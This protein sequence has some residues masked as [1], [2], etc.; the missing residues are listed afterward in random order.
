MAKR[1]STQGMKLTDDLTRRGYSPRQ[2]RPVLAGKVTKQLKRAA[3]QGLTRREFLRNTA[4]IGAMLS[5][6][7]LLS[8]CFDSDATDGAP[9]PGTERRTLFF[10]FAHEDFARTAHHLVV[11][12]NKYPL[13]K[14]SDK[15]HVLR[16]ARQTNAFL[17]GVPDNQITHHLENVELP[18]NTVQLS[19]VISSENKTT[20]TWNMSGM[21]LLMPNASIMAAHR[22]GQT[23][24]VPAGP[25]QSVKRKRY[26]SGPA[27]TAQD[28][29]DERALF[30]TTDHAGTLVGMHP[31]ALSAEPNSC[32]YIHTHHIATN[33]FTGDVSDD[34]T[35]LGAAQP[36]VTPNKPNDPTVGWATLAP[37]TDENGV[38]LKNTTGKNNKGLIHYN[39][40]WNINVAQ[41]AAQ[42][43]TGVV[44]STK[45]DDKLGA[46]VTGALNGTP[47]DFTGTIWHR[48]DGITS[49]NQSPGPGRS[50]DTLKYTLAPDTPANGYRVT[51]TAKQN[52][53]GSVPV[54]LNLEN[55]YLR[56]LG[57]WVQFLDSNGKVVPVKNLPSSLTH[58]GNGVNT[59]N[60][61]YF[62]V[63]T[64]EFVIYAI[65]IQ[66][67]KSTVT[68]NFPTGVASQAKVL[69][70]GLGFGSH[71]FQA[72]EPVGIALTSIF[73]LIIPTILLGL[74]LVEGIDAIVKLIAIPAANAAANELAAFV[75]DGSSNSWPNFNNML[76]IFWRSLV[77]TLASPGT[78]NKFLKTVIPNLVG[79]I[80]GQGAVDAVEDALPL[81]G[82]I[83]QAIAA[84]ATV[85]EIAETSIEVLLSPW[86]YENDL[87]LTHDLTLSILP[88]QHDD[89]TPKGANRYQVTALFDNGGTPQVQ[90]VALPQP[91]NKVDVT[92]KNVP[93]GGNVNISAAF[94]QIPI[95]PS[96]DHVVLGKATTG[97]VPNNIDTLAPTNI[98]EIKF[99]IGRNTKYQHKQKTALDP[100][101]HHF[102][103]ITAP[104][105]VKKAS[106]IRCAVQGDLCDFYAITVRQGTQQGPGYLGYAWRGNSAGV[107]DCTSGGQSDT[108]QLANLNTDSSNNGKN[109]QNGYTNAACGLQNKPRLT[110][111]LLTHATANY[112]LDTT[113]K[114][115]RQVQLD[116]PAFADPRLNH[117]Y[118]AF[119]LDSTTLLLH[120]TGRLVSINQANHKME[121]LTLAATPLADS[122]A[123]VNRLAQ[124]HAGQ[125]LRPGL[126]DT[127]V[128]AAI[129]ADGVIL[130]LEKNNNRIQ[131]FD[132]GAN[133]VQYFSKQKQPYFL[134]L[135][136][137]AGDT[138]Y[139][140]LAVEF[141][142]FIYVLSVN[143]SN[144]YRLDI[145]HPGQADT[146]PIATTQNVNAAR[147]TVDFWRNVYTLN[148]EVLQSTSGRAEPS[149]SL[150]VP[151]NSCVGFNCT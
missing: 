59:E 47:R 116:P 62:G 71:T 117:A 119:N 102:W 52:G 78:I 42:A 91:A 60:E 67:S 101:G 120:P 33:P 10:N 138:T 76:T 64:P 97:L 113:N 58:Q 45:D 79:Y 34:I 21:Y 99:P 30:D 24:A 12:R 17:R 141:T 38:P 66:E 81:V 143:G 9:P 118:G 41:D 103:D 142:G 39:A 27:F 110:Y 121:T 8:S 90:D 35:Q 134:S 20:G 100:S 137:T 84:V 136:A 74:G 53:D 69:A 105:P 145:Y 11:G 131:A 115:V 73:N 19:Y 150:W 108:G 61:V 2:S 147:L 140:D 5:L 15:P 36:Q 50:T 148:Y 46:D 94:V 135:T 128:A 1:R 89:T 86:T 55:W 32:A 87:V 88:D 111:N 92:F 16:Q 7:P 123:K 54:T 22:C 151:T 133:P 26:G 109:A 93:L 49:I 3:Q 48:R 85:A 28:L 68:F 75:L 72:T 31:E 98:Q 112:Y 29:V 25:L 6:P 114:V 40:E 37:V 82:A 80:A 70:S 43:I 95:D 106:D 125:G 44:Q 126:I 4:G 63:I 132:T 77:R 56:W 122:D 18:A 129:S 57:V 127:P 107:T 144:V 23:R 96:Q 13:T 130:V 51:A 139:L 83:L 104:A 146:S 14:V 65:P 149:V 124:L